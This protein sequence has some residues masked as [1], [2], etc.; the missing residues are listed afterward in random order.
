MRSLKDWADLQPLLNLSEQAD[1]DFKEARSR[2]NFAVEARKDIAA[3][4][5][6]LGGH[7]I[8]GAST[9]KNRSRCTGFHGIDALDAT[10]LASEYESEAKACRPTPFMSSHC[11][12]HPDNPGHVVLVIAVGMSPVAPVGAALRQTG[13]G[14]L[15]DE[16]WCFPYRVG[17]HTKYLSPDQFGAYESMSARRAA[18]LLSGIPTSERARLGLRYLV[19]GRSNVAIQATPLRAA[20]VAVSLDEN[21]AR[22]VVHDGTEKPMAVPLDEIVT[23]WRD[24]DG[25]EVALK[26]YVALETAAARY[27]SAC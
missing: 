25:W 14:H 26:G 2:D 11:I 12:D 22:F 5:N 4:A 17:S 16:G 20:I 6:T 21:V 13:G 27:H 9:D 1:L 7:I 19:T 8:V 10:A 15:V 18:A 24:V 23:V 3:L